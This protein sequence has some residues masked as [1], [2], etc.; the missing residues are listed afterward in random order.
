MYFFKIQNLKT[1]IVLNYKIM[2]KEQLYKIINDIC[3]FKN[4]NNFNVYHKKIFK[5]KK[6]KK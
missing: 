1:K 6:M 2:K 4:P 3:V 5:K